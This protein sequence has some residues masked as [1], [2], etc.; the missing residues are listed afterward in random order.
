MN[1]ITRP[2][3]RPQLFLGFFLAA[4][5]LVR[6]SLLGSGACSQGDEFRYWYTAQMLLAAAHGDLAGALA[7][8]FDT[9]GRPGLALVQL[10]PVIVQ[11]IVFKMTGLDPRCPDSLLVPQVWNVLVSLVGA[12][13]FFRVGRRVFGFSAAKSAWLTVAFSLLTA[14][15]IYVRHLL[16]YDFAL[17]LFLWIFLMV[18]DNKKPVWIGLFTAFAYSIYPGYFSLV[19]VVF[20]LFLFNKAEKPFSLNKLIKPVLG[21][22]IGFISLLIFYEILSLI[23]GK[24]FIGNSLFGGQEF[25]H[26]LQ[27]KYDG[28]FTFLGDYLLLVE[29]I[30]GLLLAL[31][32]IIYFIKIVA[33]TARREPLNPLD[34]LAIG[35]LLCFLFQSLIGQMTGM[36]VFYGRLMRPISMAMVWLAG[37]VFY[38]FLKKMGQRVLT[39]N[40][41]STIVMGCFLA[42]FVI[43]WIDL[44]AIGYPRDMFFAFGLSQSA[45]GLDYDIRS[46][47]PPKDGLLRVNDFGPITSYFNLPPENSWHPKAKI[48]FDSELVV[49]NFAAV[50]VPTPLRLHHEYPRGENFELLEIKQHYASFAPYFFEEDWNSRQEFILGWPL[51]I[52]IF[53]DKRMPNQ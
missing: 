12:W 8:M 6:L 40:S 41:I 35:L 5:G 20:L 49:V 37:A 17:Y 51:E 46:K 52:A 29:A 23:S 30:P 36:K 22:S 27:L 28:G 3:N 7:P 45:D 24:S 9:A 38:D 39:K 26:Y 13:L 44:R 43:F 1:L 33:K 42:H 18:F 16:P 34:L 32:S 47:T 53:K 10:P 31:G 14:S 11:S 21:F 50:P 2:E 4:I 15:T 48:G 19:L 25:L